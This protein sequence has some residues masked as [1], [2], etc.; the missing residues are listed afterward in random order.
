MDLFDGLKLA[1]CFCMLEA[2]G[3]SGSTIEHLIRRYSDYG[4]KFDETLDFLIKTGLVTCRSMRVMLAESGMNSVSNTRNKETIRHSISQKL[5]GQ[6]ISSSNP[7]AA[8][9]EAFLSQFIMR[10]GALRF[11]PDF[12]NNIRTASVR[13]FLIELDI[14]EDDAA[15]GYFVKDEGVAL[16][17][18]TMPKRPIGRREYREILDKKETLG[19]Q[20]ELEVIEIEKKRLSKYPNLIQAIQHMADLDIT[21]GYDIKSYEGPYSKYENDERLIEVKAVSLL[22]YQFHWSS[23]E[24]NKAKNSK[25]HYYLYL[26]PVISAGNFSILDLWIIKDPFT[27]VFKNTE[28]W[29]RSYESV[30]FRPF[31]VNIK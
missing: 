31:T 15:S 21:A 28:Q 12:K 8:E 19:R 3:N 17:T 11:K 1:N 10:D 25:K 5:V 14:I 16:N 6:L 7:F 4:T 13:N 30:C 2:I 23:N 27:K 9:V 26:L 29:S 22:S 18:I 20:A 24:L